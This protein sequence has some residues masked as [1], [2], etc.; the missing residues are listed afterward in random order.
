MQ[1]VEKV[2]KRSRRYLFVDGVTELQLGSFFFLQ[3][4]FYLGSEGTSAIIN[5]IYSI[6]TTQAELLNSRLSLLRYCFTFLLSLS[7]GCLLTI[8][9][10]NIKPLRERFVYPRIGYFAPR[11]ATPKQQGKW[12]FFFILI[13]AA[14][15]F[16]PAIIF[17]IIYIFAPQVAVSIASQLSKIPINNNIISLV[18]HLLLTSLFVYMGGKFSLSRFYILAALSTLL[19]VVLF[20]SRISTTT[21]M[22]TALYFTLMGLAVMISGGFTFRN[23][24]RQNPIPPEEV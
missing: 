5:S 8:I 20:Q 1:D 17:M 9:V 10:Q 13:F 12:F 16:S 4:L 3:G 14:I 22:G 11:E 7:Y 19:S 21:N 18:G 6:Q 23:L 2:I 15:L 24:L